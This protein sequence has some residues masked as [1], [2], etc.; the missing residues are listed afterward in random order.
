[1][2]Y[3]VLADLATVEVMYQFS[4]TWF[5]EMF[6][7]CIDLNQSPHS[8]VSSRHS[9]FSHS[10]SLRPPGGLKANEATQGD[11]LTAQLDK[12]ISRLT[13]SVYKIASVA[14]FAHHQLMFSFMLCTSIMRSNAYAT[15]SQ[16]PVDGATG[17]DTISQLEWHLFLQGHIMAGM[18]DDDTCKQHDGRC[19]MKE[20]PASCRWGWPASCRWGWESGWHRA[21]RGWLASYHWGWVAS[22]HWWMDGIMP[23]GDGWHA[24]GHPSLS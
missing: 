6:S 8:K 7:S 13:T 3:F 23:L 5:Y 4:L 21:V 11:D 22:Y 1:M 18:L 19:S 16:D 24:T 9:S 14:L 10:S 2:L 12:M 15:T 20:W 17:N